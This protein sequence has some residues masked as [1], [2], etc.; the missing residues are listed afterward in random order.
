MTYPYIFDTLSSATGKM[1][2]DNFN[3]ANAYVD[4]NIDL[5]IKFVN[6]IAALRALLKTGSPNAFALGYYTKGDGGGGE[7]YYD[8]QD[9]TSADN[10]GTIIVANDGG[11]WKLLIGGSISVRQFGAKGDGTTNDSTCIQAALSST[12]TSISVPSGAYRAEG[13]QITRSLTLRFDK[14]ATFKTVTDGATCLTINCHEP[15]EVTEG[16]FSTPSTNSVGG[17]LVTVTSSVSEN[18][19]SKFT[20]CKFTAPRIANQLLLNFVKGAYWTVN[21]CDFWGGEYGVV[22]KN[23]NNPDG[24]D[25]RL[26]N[27]RFWGMRV[28]IIHVSSGGLIVS[29]NKCLSGPAGIPDIFYWSLFDA[30]ISTVDLMIC[31]NSIESYATF[32]ILLEVGAGA[33][34]GDIQIQ[35]NEL[36]DYGSLYTSAVPIAVNG[37]GGQLKNISISG[38]IIRNT[39]G[40]GIYLNGC[41]VIR[42]DDNIIVGEVSGA[43][44][45]GINATATAT[46]LV[47]GANLL[48]NQTLIDV[49]PVTNTFLGNVAL[50]VV[51]SGVQNVSIGDAT[52]LGNTTGSFNTAVG[53]QALYNNVSYSNISGLGYAALVS[54]SNQ[55]QLGNNS[56]TTYVF[57]TV[58]NRSDAR[59][60]ADIR[61]TVLGLDFIN[62]LRPVDFRW[63]YRD[64][65]REFNPSTGQV[66]VLPKDGS[67]K[68]TRFHH[69]L[70]AQELQSLS[71]STGIEFGGFQDHKI[72]G[73]DDVLS[74]GYDELIAP[75]I[76]AVQ[77]LSIKVSQLYED[78]S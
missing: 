63:D 53:S 51:T 26:L 74:I 2:D 44:T 56:T 9:T 61:D 15:V 73:G 23:T 60:K 13:L 68:R 71:A 67:K 48:R 76:K 45:Q 8:S 19:N 59:D 37:A 20:N 77:E 58:Q 72:G 21:N 39:N 66:D 62:S 1:L 55:V 38:N 10:G 17:S 22:V 30:G 57:G 36:A 64:S 31:N 12:A 32:G 40:A 47:V 28:G 6:N 16:D 25:N 35:N 70:I 34:F 14:S 49:Y 42:V 18:W 50:P 7:F 33:I 29:S 54:G 3:Y 52:L 27:N 41:D 24:G 78:K 11:R 4:T 5:A 65:Y 69:G 75:L 46:H 43:Y